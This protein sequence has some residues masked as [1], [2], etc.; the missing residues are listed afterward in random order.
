MLLLF[1]VA[2][3]A[4]LRKLKGKSIVS[5]PYIYALTIAV[6]CTAWTFYG[7]V[8]EVTNSGF[9]FITIYLGPTLT[10]F[11]WGFI[12]RKMIRICR[13]NNITSIADFISSRY[14]KCSYLGALVT[15][16][17]IIGIM[18]YIALQLKSISTTFDILVH[19]DLL[20][21]F[22]GLISNTRHDPPFYLET[23]FYAA[24]VLSVFGALFGARYLDA[25][26]KHEGMVA[27]V[28]L[29]SVIKLVAFVSVG[30][31]VTYGIFDG[32]KDILQQI[33]SDETYKKLLLINTSQDNSYQSWFTMIILSMAAIICLP[34]QFHVAVIENQQE[35]H[36][37]KAMFLFPLY[38]FLI[39]LFV[40]PIAFGG[41]LVIGGPSQIADTFVLSLPLLYSQETLAVLVFIGGLSA[42]IG[43]VVVS[44]VTL[45][46]MLLNQLAMP[47][48]LHFKVNADLTSWILHLKRAGIFLVIFL[49]YIFFSLIGDSYMLVNMGLISFSAAIQMAPALIGGLYWKN[50][51]RYGAMAGLL[52][53]FLFWFYT[54]M[55]P[56]FVYSG[57]LPDTILTH[58]PAGIW[59]LNPIELFGLTGFDFYSH[60]LFW[61]LGSNIL[62]YL[63]VSLSSTQDEIGYSQAVKFVDVFKP[64]IDRFVQKKRYANFPALS[65]LEK[66]MSRF[67]GKEKARQVLV[68]FFETE[69]LSDKL[70]EMNDRQRMQLVSEVE[71]SIAGAVG[72]SAGRIICDT[73]MKALGSE[74]ENVFDIFGKISLSLEASREE[75][76]QRLKELSVLYEAS[77]MVSS[78]INLQQVMDD[79]LDLL[80]DKFGVDTCSVRLLENDG[81]IR[82][83]AQ[84]GLK[85]EFVKSAERRPSMDCYSGECFLSGRVINVPDTSKITKPISTNRIAEQGIKSFILAPIFSEKEIIGVLSISSMKERGYFSD[86]FIELFTSLAQQLG[87]AIGT[88]RLYDQLA[89]FNK[90]LEAKVAERTVA[91]ER[92]SIQLSE[93]NLELKE[94][95]RLKSEFLANMSHELRTPLNSIIGFTQLL[96]AEI[97]G[98]INREQKESLETVERNANNLLSLI[99]DILDLSKIEA[100]KMTLALQPV[101]LD[102]VID[103]TMTIMNPLIENK[104]QH[105]T[106]KKPSNLP[107]VMGD[108]E[109][110]NQILINLLS[111]AIK[112]TDP[113]GSISLHV[114][115]WVKT[116]PAGLDSSKSYVRIS[117]QDNGIGIKPEDLERLFGEFIQL[118]ASASRKYGGTGLGLSIT[119]RLVEMLQGK[120]IVKSRYG[121]GST[122]SFFIPIEEQEEIQNK[123][124]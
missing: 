78:S 14:G 93:A 38:L 110:L 81:V 31:F 115:L 87:V 122:F 45:S 65:E 96:L 43:M 117:V 114:E 105:F 61:S 107:K 40:I 42:A 11:S 53:G 13:E 27:V 80:V 37:E 6:Y 32:F 2:Y 49:G 9:K 48:L 70:A 1:G 86:K 120:I 95:D 76:R 30:L 21:D 16:I 28:A 39:N 12:L 29:G 75:L 33:I 124:Q 63:V 3:Y 57:W 59:W 10:A 67:I 90:E 41:L 82:I 88:A 94:L 34:R 25:S 7:S 72:S 98:E 47:L 91:L 46:T 15:V 22:Q 74:M 18:P 8:G 4:D 121:E 112:F 35:N 109:K 19:P 113:G 108:K 100:G 44:S 36:I 83:K 111:N 73:Y 92:K 68:D 51:N 104:K 101:S 64:T 118:D 26:E 55:I 79:I 60:S 20:L 99:N 62:V 116:L 54:L 23:A 50:G 97:D 52:L 77:R 103:D 106:L 17:A 123:R 85:P 84:R 56:S 89:R 5:N 71:K 69:D 66:M 119:R 102:D 58:G 24:L